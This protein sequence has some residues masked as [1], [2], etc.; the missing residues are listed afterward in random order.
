MADGDVLL[1]DTNFYTVKPNTPILFE[2]L[3]GNGQAGGTAMRINGASIPVNPTGPTQIG[4][5]GKDLRKSV[6]QVITTVK[7]VSQTTNKTSVT[8]KLSGGVSDESFPYAIEV[9][10]DKGIARYF[11]TYVLS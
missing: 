11:I 4:V 2:V 6:L 9:K 3:I 8:H 1:S 5:A 10:K 7:D